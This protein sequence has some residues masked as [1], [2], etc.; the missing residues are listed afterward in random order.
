MTTLNWRAYRDFYR[1]GGILRG[2]A[3]KPDLV[4]GLRHAAYAIG[5]KKCEPVWDFLIRA[6]RVARA[7][8]LLERV[9]AGTAPA[10]VRVDVPRKARRASRVRVRGRG[11][12]AR[13]TSVACWS[14]VPQFPKEEVP[15]RSSTDPPYS[16]VS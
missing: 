1:W 8:P 7:L 6:R 10:H 5:W 15:C 13:L 14:K 16:S 4:G 2:A 12:E 9:L 11:G 3:T